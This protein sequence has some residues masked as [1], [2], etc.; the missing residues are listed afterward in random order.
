MSEKENKALDDFEDDDIGIGRSIKKRQHRSSALKG[1]LFAFV[2]IFLIIGSFWVSFL[3]G[4]RILVPA[5]TFPNVESVDNEVVPVPVAPT[6]PKPVE[7]TGGIEYPN[8]NAV[9]PVKNPEV[10]IKNKITVPVSP[11]K[12]ESVP[13]A[14][15]VT[16]V[17]EEDAYYKVEAGL[18]SVKSDAIDVMKKLE[19][20]GFEVF[21]KETSAGAWRVQAG[22][23]KTIDKAEK[24]VAQL[25]AKGFSGK[26][27]KE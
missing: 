11:D 1:V 2:L 19:A 20:A 15:A 10:K 23:F 25:K 8:L 27:I 9:A 21:A 22:A 17:T 6:V 12:K 7:K 5:K 14:S 24:V 18:L 16:A 4:K 3:I 26:I 13:A